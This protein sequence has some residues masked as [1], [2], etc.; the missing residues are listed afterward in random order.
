MKKNN[1]Q[2]QKPEKE[3]PFKC[4]ICDYRCSFQPNLKR[5]F[6][7]VHEEK[8]KIEKELHQCEICKKIFQF[9]S[10]LTVHLEAGHE[11]KVSHCF[12]E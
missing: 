1:C 8:P 6:A 10:R 12:T 7:S 5:H 4:D 3:K 9:R 2:I 11:I